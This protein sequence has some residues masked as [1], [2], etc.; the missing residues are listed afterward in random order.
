MMASLPGGRDQ[1]KPLV[2]IE[3]TPIITT[4]SPVRV[5]VDGSWA[6]HG[7]LAGECD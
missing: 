7:I 3:E 5:S 6:R 1:G 4:Y 2:F